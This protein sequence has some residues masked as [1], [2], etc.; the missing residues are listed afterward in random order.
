MFI[1]SLNQM[2]APPVNAGPRVRRSQRFKVNFAIKLFTV[3]QHRRLM[4]QGRSHDLSE[5]GMAIYIPAE[6]ATGQTVQ[7]EFV[8]PDSQQRLGI[9]A[10]VRDCE[11]FRCGVQF[12]QLSTTE[13]KALEQCCE[14][15]AVASRA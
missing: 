1:H 14:R 11:G 6:L 10:I 2:P 8:V 3:V 5:D 15:L 13:H 4:L 7:I 9:S 12:D